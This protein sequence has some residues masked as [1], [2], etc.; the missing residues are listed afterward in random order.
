MSVIEGG[1]GRAAP[2]GRFGHRRAERAEGA[3]HDNCL[4]VYGH[5]ASSIG[6][7]FARSCCSALARAFAASSAFASLTR[8]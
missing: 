8:P 6:V 7:F 4:T 5:A 3:R 1:D 2:G